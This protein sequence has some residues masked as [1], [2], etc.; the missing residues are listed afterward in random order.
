MTEDV[1]WS[2]ID[3]VHLASGGDMERKCALLK[4][5]LTALGDD[6]L[7]A[8]NDHF[9]A[10]DAAA[11]HHPLWGAAYVMRGGCS[12]DSFS[13]F[14]GTLISHGRT[15]FEN[16]LADPESLADVNFANGRDVC[17]EGFQYVGDA[18]AEER[19]GEWPKRFRQYI[20]SARLGR[21]KFVDNHSEGHSHNS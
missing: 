16:A 10:A 2:L 8:F 14:R 19:F 13:D 6:E 20:V 3:G 4:E 1:F 17:Y 21:M 5:R 9:D 7:R 12:D 15:V 18:L 11:Y